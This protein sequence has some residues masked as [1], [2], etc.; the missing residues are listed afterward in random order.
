[1]RFHNKT[2]SKCKHI[3]HINR[4]HKTNSTAGVIQY[5]PRLNASQ[6]M[7][8]MQENDA[9]TTAWRCSGYPQHPPGAHGSS[10]QVTV[11]EAGARHEVHQHQ[12]AERRPQQATAGT[13]TV[14]RSIAL[15]SLLIT[16]SW[17]ASIGSIMGYYSYIRKIL[18]S[19]QHIK[20]IS[21]LYDINTN[22][23]RMN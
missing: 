21:Q 3:N 23:L 8:L 20:S 1:M 13:R 7:L 19:I 2:Y 22:L 10:E 16:I 11:E 6:I 5:F 9:A 15:T 4:V 12:Q 17:D 14:C 18:T